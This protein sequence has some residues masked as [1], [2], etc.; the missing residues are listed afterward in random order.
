ML[1]ICLSLFI[2][3]LLMGSGPCLIH[4][5]PVLIG[6]IAGTKTSALQGLKSWLVFALSR[7]VAAVFFG[8]IAGILGAELFNSLSYTLIG[9]IIRLSAGLFI[10]FLGLLITLG[11]NTKIRACGK[12]NNF[13]IQND[14]KSLM[15]LGLLIGLL[16][17]M[18]FLGI[19][20]YITMASMN[21]TQGML[22]GAAFGMGTAVSPLIIFALIAGFVP[23]LKVLKDNKA[24]VLLQKVCGLILVFFG[25]HIIIRATTGF[26]G[27]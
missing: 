24:L 22:M 5:G 18:P 21:Y 8:F 4:C 7:F 16:P 1:R 17:C 3:G 9:Y 14:T 23:G 13:F 27:L 25:A 2:T 6:Y 11:I 26:A 19:I 20:S 12:L 15:A 10:V